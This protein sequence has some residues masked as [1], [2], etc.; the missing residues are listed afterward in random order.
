MKSFWRGTRVPNSIT[1]PCV[2]SAV[3][4]RLV[5]SLMVSRLTEYPNECPN[6]CPDECPYECPN[7][8][9]YT[10]VDPQRIPKSFSWGNVQ[11]LSYLTHSL[12]QHIPQYCGS[13]WA[14]S[15]LSSLSDRIQITQAMLAANGTIDRAEEFNLSVQWL[16]NCGNGVAGSCHGGSASGAYDFIQSVGYVPV[17]TCMPY[18]ACSR[19]STEGLCPS[20]DTTCSAMNTC[21]TCFPNGTCAVVEVFPNASVVEYGTYHFPS[22][23]KLQSEILVRGP[24]K[25][26]VDARLLVNYTGGVMWD[27]PAYHSDHHNHGVSIV[28]WGYDRDRDAQYW[29]IRNSWGIVRQT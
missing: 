21:R 24:V 8:P 22:V 28:G 15:A 29:I 6:E 23:H 16:L 17:D 1:I 11:G 4:H 25:T 10:Y 9:A 5:S 19:N 2:R 20:I 26:S 13:C 7:F 14:H 27:E 3:T 18:V 12:N